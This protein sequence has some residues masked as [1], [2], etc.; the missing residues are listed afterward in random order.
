MKELF[1]CEECGEIFNTPDEAVNCENVHK[2]IKERQEKYDAEKKTRYQEILDEW[3]KVTNLIISY[4]DSYE[5]PVSLNMKTSC[6][7]YICTF[8]I[9]SRK[10]RY[11]K[12]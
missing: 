3:K 8:D 7:N 2:K 5:T 12:Y 11:G 6:G 1:K 10:S 9:G 4:I